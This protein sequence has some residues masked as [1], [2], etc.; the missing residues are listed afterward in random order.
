MSNGCT[1]DLYG[2]GEGSFQATGDN[3]VEIW[4]QGH[5]TSGAG[6]DCRD[7][8]RERVDAINGKVNDIADIDNGAEWFFH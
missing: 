8:T 4:M 1:I 5:V 2:E 6:P 7:S 3:S